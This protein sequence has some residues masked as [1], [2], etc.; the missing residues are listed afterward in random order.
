MQGTYSK[1]AKVA[2]V[3]AKVVSN[4]AKMKGVKAALAITY[5][6]MKSIISRVILKEFAEEFGKADFN[7]HSVD[8]IRYLENG[9]HTKHMA[10][11]EIMVEN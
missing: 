8:N 4:V 3:T 9:F 1:G 6:N 2:A 10:C 11:T 7:I 5:R